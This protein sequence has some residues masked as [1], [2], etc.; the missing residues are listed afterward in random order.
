MKP[1]M[2]AVTMLALFAPASFAH[3]TWI[4]ADPPRV[5]SGGQVALHI[6]SGMG[7]PV[8][9]TAPK[10]SRIASCEWRVGGK[11]GSLSSFDEKDSSLVVQGRVNTDG[12]AVVYVEFHP[13]EIDLEADQVKH[14]MDEIGAP[15]SV[16]RAWEDAGPDAKFHETYTKHAKTYLRIGD[17]GD[18]KGCLGPV[19]FAIDFLPESDP[20]ALKVG[21]TLTIK[22]IR[23][24]DELE[25]FPVGTVGGNKKT[26]MQRTSDAGMVAVKIDSPGWWLVRGTELR[27]NSDDTWESDFTTLTFFVGNE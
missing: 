14:Y 17:S 8:F 1:M 5:R 15:E 10:S 4:M 21:D 25:G 11:T 9:E 3:D 19:G 20:T 16:R 13:K 27:R 2:V 18:A 6:S 12:V 7:F 26:T 23:G 24:G 22:V